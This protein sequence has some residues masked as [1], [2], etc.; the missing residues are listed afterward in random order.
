VEATLRERRKRVTINK[1]EGNTENCNGFKTCMDM[2]RIMMEK[3]MLKER[4]M[5]S[6][7]VGIG[8]I[9]T[10]R[11]AITAMAIIAELDFAASKKV[12]P[13]IAS[14]FAIFYPNILIFFWS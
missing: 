4:R 11:I 3:V 1:T 14:E 13:L 9:M 12:F 7:K 8:I 5:S 6:K 2:S 10:I